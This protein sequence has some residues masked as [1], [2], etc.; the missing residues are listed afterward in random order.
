[1]S[2]EVRGDDGNTVLVRVRIDRDSLDPSEL[3]P[4]ATVTGR[5]YCGRRAIGYVWFHD[6]I[7]F[8]RSKLLFRI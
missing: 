4:G 6:V 7:A 8:I 1:S 5:I 2:A 3:R